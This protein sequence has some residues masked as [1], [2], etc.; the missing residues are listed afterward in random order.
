MSRRTDFDIANAVSAISAAPDPKACSRI[1][2]KAIAA[3]NI[4]AFACGEIDLAALERTVF[5]AI[6]WPDTW[7]KF[8]VG[9]GVILRDPVIAALKQRHGPFTWSELRRDGKYSAAGTKVLQ[10]VAEHGWTE[11]LAVPIPRGDQGFGP[12]HLH[13]IDGTRCRSGTRPLW[14]VRGHDGRTK[15]KTTT[16]ATHTAA[17][18]MTVGR[19]LFPPRMDFGSLAPS[20]DE[21][22]TASPVRQI[23]CFNRFDKGYFACA[24]SISTSCGPSS[25]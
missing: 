22:A 25:R 5:Y 23:L 18:A 19:I 24:T 14:S 2:R 6:G 20:P 12:H 13:D 17:V 8:Y 15:K 10:V 9:T 7:H 1:F 21:L 16:M 11:G 3:F 4:D